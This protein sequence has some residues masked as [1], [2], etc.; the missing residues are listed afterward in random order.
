MHKVSNSWLVAILA[1]VFCALA[2]PAGAENTSEDNSTVVNPF[3]GRDDLVGEGKSLF[4]LHC[5]HCH[6]P[7]AFQGERKRDLRRLSK[8][9]GD[10]MTAMFYT[11]AIN[12]RPEKGMPTWKGVLE[13]EVLWKIFTFLETVQKK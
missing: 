5:S 10:E 9:Y 6:G 4:N 3:A 12:G 8:K 1:I 7:N 11:T 2:G 13:D